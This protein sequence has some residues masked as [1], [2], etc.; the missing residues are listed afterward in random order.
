MHVTLAEELDLRSRDTLARVT[1]IVLLFGITYL[2]VFATLYGKYVE[3]DSYYSHG[4]AG[5]WNWGSWTW[6]RQS[7][8]RARCSHGSTGGPAKATPWTCSA[9]TSSAAIG[10]FTR[11]KCRSWREGT[12]SSGP[13]SFASR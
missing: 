10:A 11:R 4:W 8:S 12:G 9:H 13:A 5:T 7:W 2:P 6:S 1:G 3:V